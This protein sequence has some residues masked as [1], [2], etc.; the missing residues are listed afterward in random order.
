M[1]LPVLSSFASLVIIASLPFPAQAQSS[2]CG[3]SRTFTKFYDDKDRSCQNIRINPERQ[4]AMCAFEDVV[5]NCRQTCG[6][7]C[8]DEPD[9][10]FELFNE[11]ELVGCSWLAGNLERASEY[12]DI[13]RSGR[14][15][16]DACPFSCSFCQPAVLPPSPT[17]SPVPSQIVSPTKVPTE[18]PPTVT[19]A[20]SV[21]GC[22]DDSLFNFTLVS[23]ANISQDCA[24]ITKKTNVIAIRKGIYCGIGEIKYKGCP[25]TCDGCD[26]CSDDATYQ[27]ELK[28]QPGK[29][30]WCLWLRRSRNTARRIRTYCPTAVGMKCPQSCGYCK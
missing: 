26:T 1:K 10:R 14:V 12:C 28:Y 18:Q 9:F 6:L 3:N 17:L 7:C 2:I 13:W 15:I 4:Q 25:N 22:V 19:V 8:A 16:R 21:A 11:L 30:Q 5:Q 27:F 20:P 29:F 23:D 24:W